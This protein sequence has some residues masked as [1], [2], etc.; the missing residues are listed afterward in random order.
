MP[1]STSVD[2]YSQVLG[3]VRTQV[4]GVC[5][6]DL[7]RTTPCSE[8][9]VAALVGHVIGAIEYYTMLARDGETKVRA[10]TVDLVP[11]DDGVARF[12]AAAREGL[13]AWS[14]PGALDRDCRMVLGSMPTRA[15]LAIHVADLAVHAWDIA[16]ALGHTLVLPDTLASSAY[17]TWQDVFT[18]LDRGV[19]FAAEMP[20]GVDASPTELL[21]AYCGRITS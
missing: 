20:A 19:A 21:V 4:A 16:R 8:W 3:I 10:V 5:D 1:T 11:G 9:D 6:D 15:A 7:A 17:V 14:A 2:T 18:R 13:A 12:D